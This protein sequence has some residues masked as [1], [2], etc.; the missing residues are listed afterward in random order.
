M[1]INMRTETFAKLFFS[2]SFTG[3]IMYGILAFYSFHTAYTTVYEVESYYTP[4]LPKPTPIKQGSIRDPLKYILIWTTPDFKDNSL[5]EGQDPF[6]KNRC[7]HV[8]CFLSTKKN[9]NYD[10]VLMDISILRR[11]LWKQ[12]LPK[13]R[14]PK[15]KFVFHSMRSAEETPI[16]NIRADNYFNWTWSYKIYSDIS[17]PFIEVKDLDGNV[18]APKPDVKWI[19]N[20]KKLTDL[21]KRKLNTK[22]KAVAWMPESCITRTN[23]ISYVKKLQEAL[24]DRSLELDVYGCNM[25]TIT[26]CPKG[27]CLKLLETDYYFYLAFEATHAE[28]YVTTEVLK[29]Y[30]HSTVPI[31]KGGADYT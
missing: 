15:Q 14:S 19:E 23:R 25:G 7:S 12:I 11:S 21:D 18:I 28:D 6:L 16:C 8:N 24:K 27:E 22:K 9:L 17:T 5:G 2:V 3:L 29:A 26:S 13:N 30:H 20:M 10:V 1:Y 4:G 31:V